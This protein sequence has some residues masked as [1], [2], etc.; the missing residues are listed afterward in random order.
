VI[1]SAA[2]AA[3]AHAT[4]VRAPATTNPVDKEART[5]IPRPILWNWHKRE[6]FVYHRAF[7]LVNHFDM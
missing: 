1:N 6:D 7:K 2:I 3:V 4:A 5:R